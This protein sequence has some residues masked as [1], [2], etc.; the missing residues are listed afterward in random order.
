MS[1]MVSEIKECVILKLRELYPNMILYDE[2]ISK[3]FKKPSF[4]ITIINVIH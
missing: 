3:D 2:K 4:F 1:D